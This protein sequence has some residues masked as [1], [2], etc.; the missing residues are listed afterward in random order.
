MAM[1]PV[2]SSIRVYSL[3]LQAK[4]VPLMLQQQ[5]LTGL[6]SILSLEL[7]RKRNQNSQICQ[8][9]RRSER[10]RS[11]LCS[12]TDLRRLEHCLR[13]RILYERPSNLANLVD[14]NENIVLLGLSLVKL[15]PC[16]LFPQ[17]Q[18]IIP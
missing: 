14:D 1:L 4:V 3:P 6:P 17:I 13:T 12:L 8:T 7:L 18:T 5:P 9:R 10:W 2:S 15:A 11:C 16:S